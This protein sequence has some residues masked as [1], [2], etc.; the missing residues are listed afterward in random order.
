MFRC[1]TVLVVLV[2]MVDTEVLSS[3]V[4]TLTNCSFKISAWSV[5]SEWFMP[6]FFSGGY[7]RAVAF[8]ILDVGKEFSIVG[9]WF[10]NHV[11]DVV[12]MGI[13]TC[14]LASFWIFL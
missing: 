4:K 7:T 2:P 14:M 3:L 1:G 5:G 8:H 6:S 10:N 9:A 12:I 13:S 11:S